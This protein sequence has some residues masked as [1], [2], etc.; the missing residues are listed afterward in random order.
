[1]TQFL[2]KLGSGVFGDPGFDPTVLLGPT[3]PAS[4]T[5]AGIP[6]PP[7]RLGTC[8]NGSEGTEF[9]LC[10]AV[11]AANTDLLPGEFWTFDRNYLAVKLTTAL[12]VLNQEVAVGVVFAN[13]L[14]AGTYYVWL[15]RAGHLPVRAAAASVATGYG[16]TT[17]TAGVA[18]F[19]AT[20]TVGALSINPSS[21][22]VASA[23]VTFT[24]NTTSG[25]PTLTNVSSIADLALGQAI[26]GTGIPANANICAIRATGGS[27]QIDIGTTTANTL[28][29]LQNATANGSAITVT[30]TLT[31]PGN[32]YWPTL[33]KLN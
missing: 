28:T 23:G 27:F 30:G 20:A 25:S 32:V 3:P 10:K 11:L 6:F 19:P 5:G 12:G 29:T 17:T 21:V 24:A 18:K 8:T 26:A 14:A 22:Y 13:N 2:G 1:M 33:N 4:V 9:V 31:L 16:E 15:A 7:A